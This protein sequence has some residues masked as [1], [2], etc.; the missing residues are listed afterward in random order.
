MTERALE[1]ITAPRQSLGRGPPRRCS[2][3]DSRHADLLSPRAFRQPSESAGTDHQEIGSLRSI[4]QHFRH[5]V[6]SANFAV[7]S[8]PGVFAEDVPRCVVQDC[9]RQLFRLETGCPTYAVGSPSTATV[10]TAICGSLASASV[11]MLFNARSAAEDTSA[12]LPILLT[13]TVG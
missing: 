10:W 8:Q 9:R 7:K 11:T 13:S 6:S 1:I 2:Q 5:R 3:R 4:D 12:R